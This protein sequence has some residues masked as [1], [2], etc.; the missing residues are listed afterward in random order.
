MTNNGV[1]R[2]VEI[3][4]PAGAGKTTLC[5][6]LSQG[7]EFIHPGNFPDVRKVSAAP[8]F[9]WNGLQ[10]YSALLGLPQHNSRKLTRRE[11]AW[12]SILYGWPQVLQK[13]MKNKKIIILD[14]GPVYL[15]T[16]IFEFGPEYLAE[17]KAKSLWRNLYT[18][19]ADTLDTIVWLDAPD[20]DLLNRI[21]SRDK[22]HVVKN[23]SVEA[24]VELF[25]RYRNAYEWIISSLSAYQ[26]NLKILWFDTSQ[27][28]PTQIVNHILD[29]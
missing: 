13:E 28:T 20:T 25:I 14:Q 29:V 22:E 23:I 27:K 24:T 6:V 8:F 19:W 12:L 3:V 21:R 2:I 7:N 17:Q 10:I 1:P 15:L 16:E 5:K 9:I 18:R 11:F 26:P 4:G